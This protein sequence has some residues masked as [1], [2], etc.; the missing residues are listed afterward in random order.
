M[1]NEK[2][3]T[4]EKNNV[5]AAAPAAEKPA[6]A[7]AET[8]AASA[9]AEENPAD[10]I[11]RQKKE[12]ESFSTRN[13]LLEQQNAAIAKWADD[14]KAKAESAEKRVKDLEKKIED[15]RA[16]AKTAEMIAAEKYGAK[17]APAKS[18]HGESDIRAQYAAVE[19]DPAKRARFLNSL[20]A[21]QMSALR[22][23]LRAK[24]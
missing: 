14:L 1:E 8:Q 4:T 12:I 16:A 23:S 20:N 21:G 3:N 2:H 18:E 9:A 15:L 7:N 10:V 22:E 5:A 11:A 24:K 13:D 6:V 19:A 17:A